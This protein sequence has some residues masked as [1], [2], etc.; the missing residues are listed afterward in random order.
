VRSGPR[1]TGT[2][3]DLEKQLQ[4]ALAKAAEYELLGSLAVD[5]AKR[6]ECRVKA[7]FYHDAANELRKAIAKTSAPDN[8]APLPGIKPPPDV[9]RG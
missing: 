1:E 6:E 9:Y 5:A 3:S 8:P 7:Q 4:D 2:M